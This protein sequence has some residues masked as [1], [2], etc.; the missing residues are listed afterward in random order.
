M[1]PDTPDFLNYDPSVF[2]LDVNSSYGESRRM[3]PEM[4]MISAAQRIAKQEKSENDEPEKLA[5]SNWWRAGIVANNLAG[6]VVTAFRGCWH[7]QL[8][9]PVC[10]K[11]C[12]YQVCLSCGAKRL[13]DENTFSAYGRFRYDLDECPAWRDPAKPKPRTGTNGG[14]PI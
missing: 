10:V 6:V 4:L 13:F 7:S 8:S 12:S 5:K 1:P 9:W 3:F 2:A 11:G 14:Y